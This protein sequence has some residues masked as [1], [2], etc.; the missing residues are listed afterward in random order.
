M[1]YWAHLVGRRAAAL[2]PL[3][4]S[5]RLAALGGSLVYGL[6]PEKRRHAVANMA[7][8]V[9]PGRPPRE[10]RRLARGAFRNYGKYLVDMMR[11]DG[12]HM[13]EVERHLR[14]YGLEH[15]EEA[16]ARG[17]RL[18]FVGGHLGNSALGGAILA[19]RGYPVPVIAEI[20]P[21]PRWNALVQETRR[22]TG[23][24]VIAHNA[25]AR[26]ILGVLRRNQVLA[27]L[28]DRP[29]HHE[30]DGVP[31]RFF[32]GWTRVPSGAATLALRTRAGLIAPSVVR[33]GRGY[34]VHISPLLEVERS[35]DLQ[36]DIQALTQQAGAALEGFIR[37]YPDQWFM[38]RPMWPSADS[39]G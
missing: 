2:L 16:L 33:A 5:Y 4:L 35:G 28:I 31:V 13:K 9:G 34:G 18:I 1:V 25:S 11:L 17:P 3:P 21:P 22:L 10:A 7:R 27:F 30:G 26:E 39:A 6:W 37:Q 38:F 19:G 8:V 23:M 12:W 15:G 14:V 20:L 32:D 29:T 36:T 24:G